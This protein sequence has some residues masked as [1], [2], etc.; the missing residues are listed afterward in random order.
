MPEGSDPV[1]FNYE[2]YLRQ[3]EAETAEKNSGGVGQRV[4]AFW[5]DLRTG[6]RALPTLGVG[7]MAAEMAGFNTADTEQAIQR[8]ALKAANEMS[9]TAVGLGKE[10]VKRTGL[11]Q[12]TAGEQGEEDFLEW[13]SRR[14]ADVN[15]LQVD[16]PKERMEG[17]YGF[18]EA[19]TQFA[20][21]YALA[22]RVTPSGWF[23]WAGRFKGAVAGGAKGAAV[24]FALFDP[25]EERLSNL[26]QSGPEWVKNPLTDF[27]QAEEDDG[28]LE[29]RAKAVLE[30]V[31]TGIA[32]DAVI[33]GIK[34]IR[35]VGKVRAGKMQVEEAEAEFLA[36]NKA[37]DEAVSTDVVEV[38]HTPG[39]PSVIVPKLGE[40]KLLEEGTTED[41]L[42]TFLFQTESGPLEV[43]VEQIGDDLVVDWIG[44][45]KGDTDSRVQIGPRG[46]KA[47]RKFLAE[48]YPTAKSASGLRISG[49]R[50]EAGELRI[51]LRN[52]PLPSSAPIDPLTAEIVPPQPEASGL[53]AAPISDTETLEVPSPAQ[54]ESLAAAINEAARA[55]ERPRK[56]TPEMIGRFKE[57]LERIRAGTDPA[58]AEA[59]T[60]GIQFNFNRTLAPK[61]ALEVINSLSE[62]AKDIDIPAVLAQRVGKDGKVVPWDVTSRLGDGL[63][64]GMT[65]EQ[66]IARAAE[67]RKTTEGLPEWI[68]AARTVMYG[69]GSEVDRLSRLADADPDNPVLMTEFME[70]L[71]SLFALRNELAPTSSSVA[72]ALDAHRIEVD[73]RVPKD[74]K[75]GTSAT[76]APRGGGEEAGGKEKA[77]RERGK[78]PNTYTV[79]DEEEDILA[80]ML[81]GLVEEETEALEGVS[82]ELSDLEI[83]K[84]SKATIGVGADDFMLARERARAAKAIKRAADLRRKIGIGDE[85]IPEDILLDNASLRGEKVSLSAEMQRSDPYTVSDEDAALLAREKEFAPKP[86]N[87][88]EELAKA[89]ERE[90]KIIA[91]LLEL[92]EPRARNKPDVSPI[93][94]YIRKAV[95]E[96]KQIALANRVWS[97]SK[98]GPSALPSNGTLSGRLSLA[99]PDRKLSEQFSKTE[100][101]ALARQVRFAEGD[102]SRILKAL[103]SH[104]I[105]TDPEAMKD[106][107][108]AS[109]V[110]GFR[111][112]MMLSGP[113]TQVVNFVN[114]VL[115]AFQ[116]PAEHF[117][118]GVGRGAVT[119]DWD[120]ARNGADLFVGNFL[121]LGDALRAARK[122]L[123]D[124]RAILDPDHLTIEDV[125]DPLRPS[126]EEEGAESV[127][128]RFLGSAINAPSRV[129]MTTDELFKQMSY[130]SS[131]RAQSLR[132]AREAARARGLKG[133]ELRAFLAQRVEEDLDMA[134]DLRGGA[135]NPLAL[136][137]AR[138]ATFTN[139]LESGIGKSLQDM[140]NEHPL[141]RL[142]F[143]FVRTPV[144]IFRF[145]WQRTPVLGAFQKQMRADWSAGGE[146]RAI[147]LARQ[148]A[149]TVMYSAA[150]SLAAGRMITGGGPKNPDIRKQWIEAGNQPYSLRVGDKWYPYRRMEPLATPLSI[151]ADLVEMSGELGD[152]DAGDAVNVS[153]AA[154]MSSVSSKTFLLGMT[155]FFDAAASGEGWRVERLTTSLAGSFLPNLMRQTNPDPVWRE[156]RGFVDELAA[157]TYGWS[158]TLEPRRNLFGEVMVKP[159]GYFGR[160]FNPFASM[161][162]PSDAVANELLTLGEAMPMPPE[163]LQEYG[164]DLTDRTAWDNGTGQSPYD[165][166]M[167]LMGKPHHGKSL[168]EAL[169][170][171]VQSEAWQTASSGT[172]AFPG[173]KKLMIA[174]E[175]IQAYHERAFSSM[176]KEYPAL[177]DS[178][179]QGRRNKAAALRGSGALLEAV[180]Q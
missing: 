37:A 76:E 123:K 158:E 32:A 167:E 139:D 169:T 144:N 11:Y 18:V 70:A 78:G 82:K 68:Y 103:R 100:L 145:A 125:L 13:Y 130:R 135:T 6:R 71:D 85:D 160:T 52:D 12:L 118:A 57:T 44:G 62:A 115:T 58:D 173:G 51:P 124:G 149:G 147:F 180:A 166:M 89:F 179:Q 17:A 3:H 65:G 157:R 94:A 151:I 77:P 33:S 128:K 64:D 170:D 48:R 171:R 46:I 90:Q 59:L 101:L 50:S 96:N 43:H 107:T 126:F 168:R 30:G 1:D 109:K 177:K 23:S 27:L 67:I 95:K 35:V 111:A 165:R 163:K 7:G 8:G 172:T 31:L 152:V 55:A 84:R 127:F 106:P 140:A 47:V 22:G 80:S 154:M 66:F 36:I 146:R 178:M 10:V 174:R 79:T 29:A 102:P 117:F 87:P 26:I 119:G 155:E 148:A 97:L 116:V 150:A 20:T 53:Q 72:R 21:G 112:N 16:V 69:L 91:G 121:M 98:I 38:V 131:V 153:I 24:D 113:K 93:T 164:I 133:D 54:A 137:H 81:R 143:P 28:E 41:N 61:E 105:A 120:L 40:I 110:L 75:A 25:W 2:E 136:Q 63:I 83:F 156:T 162:P 49:A 122:A 34:R 19:A 175:V 86:S 14:T 176:L 161:D 104:H 88:I 142:I 56:A 60:R 108:I 132:E 73:G 5:R 42:D 92:K 159:P 138:Y 129:L 114:N 4:A 74:L 9:N 45:K 134:T 141:I 15:P 39:E 99:D